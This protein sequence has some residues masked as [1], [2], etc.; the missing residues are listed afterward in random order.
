MKNGLEKWA[1]PGWSDRFTARVPAAVQQKISGT[2]TEA[3][4]YISDY[5]IFMGKLRNENGEQRPDGIEADLALG[6]ARRRNRNLP[7]LQEV[8][9]QRMIS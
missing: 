2:I 6:F 5:N 7:I 8:E 4:A 3:D 9:K 1:T